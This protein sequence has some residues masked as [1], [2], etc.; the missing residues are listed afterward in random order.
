VTD[1]ASL[2]QI[3]IRCKVAIILAADGCIRTIDVAERTSHAQVFIPFWFQFRLCAWLK[4]LRLVCFKQI[5]ANFFLF[6]SL[7]S[8]CS[9]PYGYVNGIIDL[10][11]LCLSGLGGIGQ[12]TLEE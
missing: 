1:T 6:K 3:S 10:T 12:G 2:A 8:Q 4:W 5:A 9:S 7:I 11:G